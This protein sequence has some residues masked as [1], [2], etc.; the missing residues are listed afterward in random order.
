MQSIFICYFICCYAIFLCHFLLMYVGCSHFMFIMSFAP[1][2]RFLRPISYIITGPSSIPALHY[3]FQRKS[4]RAVLHYSI[5][6]FNL[7]CLSLLFR[8]SQM[9]LKIRTITISTTNFSRILRE[10]WH[11]KDNT[12]LSRNGF[13]KDMK[14]FHEVILR[15]LYICK[16]ILNFNFPHAKSCLEIGKQH[17]MRRHS[18]IVLDNSKGHSS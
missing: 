6:L 1:I 8:R 12:K 5:N 7:L 18:V 16:D 15:H 4:F 2:W 9:N 13:Q 14:T 10:L 17:K 11:L 3:N